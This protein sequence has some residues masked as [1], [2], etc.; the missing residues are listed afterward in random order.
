MYLMSL[1]LRAYNELLIA[2]IQQYWLSS[3]NFIS[4]VN[5]RGFQ[6]KFTSKINNFDHVSNTF[7]FLNIVSMQY[8][9]VGYFYPTIMDLLQH[10][11]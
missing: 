7:V 2:L 9:I 10:H 4:V 8:N 3:N 11:H 1:I 5:W 6:S